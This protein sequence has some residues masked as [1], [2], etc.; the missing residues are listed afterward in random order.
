MYIKEPFVWGT[1]QFRVNT[2]STSAALA[3][4]KQPH[5]NEQKF[6]GKNHVASGKSTAK[7]L[8]KQPGCQ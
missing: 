8:N 4:I 1:M 3:G 7:Q 6:A 5:K 2:G